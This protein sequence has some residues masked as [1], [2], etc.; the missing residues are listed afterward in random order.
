MILIWD[1]LLPALTLFMDMLNS[2]IYSIS[3]SKLSQHCPLLF[4]MPQ[5]LFE[6]QLPIPSRKIGWFHFS[7][8]CTFQFSNFSLIL[9]LKFLEIGK[10]IIIAFSLFSWLQYLTCEPQ[11]LSH[12]WLSISTR[13]S[14]RFFNSFCA[15]TILLPS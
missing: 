11:S 7:D 12:A 4:Q 15:W 8:V 5:Q 14:L 1:S 13:S 3:V 10:S 6:A 9:T 2:Y